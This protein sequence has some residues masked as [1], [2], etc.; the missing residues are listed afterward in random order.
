[1]ESSFDVIMIDQ[2]MTQ[3]EH[4]IFPNPI[5]PDDARALAS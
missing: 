1:M 5:H 3:T 4:W 2:S